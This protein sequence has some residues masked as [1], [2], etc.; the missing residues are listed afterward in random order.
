MPEISLILLITIH[1]FISFVISM[2]ML[3]PIILCEIHR[4]SVKPAVF[5]L[6]LTI[7]IIS[8]L[9]A[10]YFAILYFGHFYSAI[11]KLSNNKAK[12]N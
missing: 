2:M 11:C 6:F 7:V 3:M 8:Y 9:S 1:L 4:N 5:D 12:V 10:V